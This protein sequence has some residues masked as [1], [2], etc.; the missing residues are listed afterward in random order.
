MHAPDPHPLAPVVIGVAGGSGSGK[1]TVAVRVREEVAGRSVA[2]IHHDSYYFDNSHLPPAERARL[3]YDHP[4]AF[5]TSLLV[6]HLKALKRGE[7]VAIPVY[8]YRTHTRSPEHRRLEPADI[9]FVEGIL[10]LESPSL[11]DLMDIRLFVDVVADERLIRR[12]RRDISERGR[13]LESV[14]HQ[15]Q[16]VVRPMHDQFV[17]PS[18]RYAHLI[19]PEGGHNKVAIDLITTKI[20]QIIRERSE[21]RGSAPADATGGTA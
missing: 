4:E 2:V 11:R 16:T 13:S 7:T 17:E 20:V 18:K 21:L 6:E 1:T 15:Y 5:E 3:N 14:V 8:D 10:V 9:V 19:I 12:L